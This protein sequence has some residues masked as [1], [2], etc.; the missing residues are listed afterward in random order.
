[1]ADYLY[2]VAI[3][4]VVLYKCNSVH[5]FTNVQIPLD[6]PYQTLS[7]TRV[8]DKV[9]WV[10]CRSIQITVHG[11]GQ[12]L[13]LVGSGLVSFLNSTTRTRPDQTHGPLGS[14]TR[15]PDFVWSQTCLLN[16]DMYG[17]CPWV[18]S[19]RVADAVRGSVSLN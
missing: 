1:M 12:T 19:G 11:P 9:C 2:G 7:E 6:R 13:S 10:H 18:W 3:G 15:P 16:L 5:V 14:P 8:S 4:D 17:L